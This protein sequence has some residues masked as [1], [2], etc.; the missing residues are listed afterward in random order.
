ADIQC[1]RDGAGRPTI[2]G[3]GLAGALIETAG[4]LF[5][6]LFTDKNHKT[7]WNRIT[8]KGRKPADVEEEEEEKLRQSLWHFWPSHPK[9]E[10]ATEAGGGVG[11]RQAPGAT[12]A[13]AR[14]LFDMDTIPAGQR[15]ELFFEIDT[16]RGRDYDEPVEAVALLALWEWTEGRCWLGAS[17]ARG[18]G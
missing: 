11:L 1:A 7:G 12:A 6:Q 2:P 8:G 13:E 18:L 14:A 5:P 9:L 17:A 3:T 16:W 15:W 4:R 10:L